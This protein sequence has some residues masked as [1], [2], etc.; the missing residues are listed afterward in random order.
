MTVD[1]RPSTAGWLRLFGCACL[2]LLLGLTHPVTAAEKFKSFKL[3]SLDGASK[4][5]E[6]YK[7]KAT[8]I[9]FFFPTCAYCNKAFPETVKIY[10][11]YKD[12]GLT[13][14]WINIV[15]EEEGQIQ[16]WLQQHQYNVPV[17]IGASQQYLMNRYGVEV[18]PDHFLVNANGEILFHQRGYEDGYENELEAQVRKALS[19]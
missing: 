11:K 10:D 14:V 3:K 17:L 9:A 13:M 6:D 16:P 1:R 15:K 12:Q 18:T 19:L 2:I 5:L 4:T 7:S 8:L